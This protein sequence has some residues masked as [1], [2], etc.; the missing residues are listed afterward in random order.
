LVRVFVA[1]AGTGKGHTTQL[2]NPFVAGMKEAGAEVDIANI[3]GMDIR[4]C[5]GEF[6]CW[7][8]FPGK[9][10]IRDE[11]QSMLPRIAAAEAMVL[12]TP[13]YLPLPGEMQT[14]LNRLM[15]LID[16]LIRTENGLMSAIPREGVSLKSLA[17]V[18]SSGWWE[19]DNFDVPLL[20]ARETA[21]KAGLEFAGAILRPHAFLLGRDSER[22]EVVRKA[23]KDAGSEMIRSGRIPA[24]LQSII[25]EPLA[26]MEEVETMYN[27]MREK[28]MRSD[29]R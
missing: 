24:D 15:P 8:K 19:I 1:N 27:R 7:Y 4:P 14:F 26:T 5:V 28:T 3:R 10:H 22:S 12:S 16:P 9:C 23:T 17:L 18:S 6:N 21:R 29:C 25:S 2:L 11:M 20:I 13:V